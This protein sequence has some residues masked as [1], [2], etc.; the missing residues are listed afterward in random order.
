MRDNEHRLVCEAV[1]LA[2]AINAVWS[3]ALLWA[4]AIAWTRVYLGVHWPT[5][6][7]GGW[8]FGAA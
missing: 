3:K 8:A 5:N 6:V 1:R 7:A 2:R 4:A